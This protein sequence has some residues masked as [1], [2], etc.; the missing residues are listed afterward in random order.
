MRVRIRNSS[1]SLSLPSGQACVAKRNSRKPLEAWDSFAEELA[2]FVEKSS[3][4]IENIYMPIKTPKL[5]AHALF[6]RSNRLNKQRFTLYHQEDASHRGALCSESLKSLEAFTWL[7]LDEDVQSVWSSLC[8][9]RRGQRQRPQADA[10]AARHV[11]RRRLDVLPPQSRHPLNEFAEDARLFEECEQGRLY[12]GSK[13]AAVID[14]M[15]LLAKLVQRSETGQSF[16]QMPKCVDP[17]DSD[18]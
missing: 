13:P 16:A 17:A 6:K 4:P 14:E 10:A 9:P 2:S 15:D 11:H 7:H 3:A 8:S 5:A 18:G 1:L 12:Q